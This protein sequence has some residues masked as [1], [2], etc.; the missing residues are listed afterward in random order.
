MEEDACLWYHSIC[1]FCI[2]A[3]HIFPQKTLSLVATSHMLIRGTIL[4]IH[5]VI[6]SLPHSSFIS[7]QHP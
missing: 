3:R 2:R 5:L 4:S 7:T 6:L 1:T